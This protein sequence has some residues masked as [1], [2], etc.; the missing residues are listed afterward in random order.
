MRLFSTAKMAS[1]DRCQ[2][3]AWHASPYADVMDRHVGVVCERAYPPLGDRRRARAPSSVSTPP[4]TTW[5]RGSIDV[6]VFG[7]TV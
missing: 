7:E 1:N 6:M 5:K 4:G 3:D 2:P